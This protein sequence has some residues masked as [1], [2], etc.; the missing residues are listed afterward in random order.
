[1]NTFRF[2]SLLSL[3]AC[4]SALSIGDHFYRAYTVYDKLPMTDSDALAAG[5]K[6]NDT[7][8]PDRGYAATFKNSEATTSYPV[9]LFFTAGG[10]ISGVGVNVYGDMPESL[11][12]QRYFEIVDTR[13]NFISVTFRNS[14]I[15]CSGA[16]DN[17]LPLGDSLIINAGKLNEFLPLYES[18][19]IAQG[20]TRGACFYSMG[21]HYF[22]DLAT[23][24]RMSWY[25]ANL[26]PVIVMY[27]NGVINSFFFA[28]WVIQQGLLS[29]NWWE[30]VALPN[31]LMCKNW[32]DSSCTFH[33]TNFF[34][35]MHFYLRDYTQATCEGGCTIG[36]CP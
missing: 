29:P 10:Q 28:S 25:A 11:V 13:V 26:E 4:V 6:F 12:D 8:D 21:H 34:S 17:Q 18:D 23:A 9:T 32:C 27:N 19:A 2:F 30:P 20:W 7:C 16:I 5:W 1:M 36:C 14:S 22:F 33:D 24:P 31:L 15:M 35:T 3:I